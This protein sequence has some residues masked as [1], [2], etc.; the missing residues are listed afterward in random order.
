MKYKK[1]TIPVCILFFLYSPLSFAFQ[2]QFQQPTYLL[3]KE[4]IQDIYTCDES[5]EECKVNFSVIDDENMLITDSGYICSWNFWG[6]TSEESEKCNPN[7][8]VYPV[9]TWTTSVE[10]QEKWTGEILWNQSMT[11]QN[12]PQNTQD[13]PEEDTE[14]S[15]WSEEYFSQWVIP[16]KDSHDASQE[17]ADNEDDV[18]TEGKQSD[19]FDVF[20]VFQSPTYLTNPYSVVQN[21][22]S[23]DSSKTECKVNL[24]LTQSADNTLL[25]GEY[26]CEWDFGFE[27]DIASDTCNPT[28]IVYPVWTFSIHV[29]VWKKSDPTFLVE[30]SLQITNTGYMPQKSWWWSSKNS[31]LSSATKT[32][33]SLPLPQIIIQ[34]GVDDNWN[35]TKKDCKTNFTSSPWDN[36]VR[37]EWKFPGGSFTKGTDQKC[38]P[39]MVTYGEWVF[40]VTLTYYQKDLP[41][42][43]IS[44][45]VKLTNTGNI[46]TPIVKNTSATKKPTSQP[47]TESSSAFLKDSISSPFQ[48]TTLGNIPL[49]TPDIWEVRIS[50]VLPY[51][52]SDEESFLE[53]TNTT[54]NVFSLAWCTLESLQSGKYDIMP[55]WMESI[56]SKE[57]RKISGKYLPTLSHTGKESVSL[58]CSS[59]TIDS[60]LRN[61]FIPK[62]FL[63]EPKY[64]VQ[65]IQYIEKIPDIPRY[66]IT[67]TNNTTLDTIVNHPLRDI[68]HIALLPISARE[69]E[70]HIL[71]ILQESFVYDIETREEKIHIT[72][73]TL[74]SMKVKITLEWENEKH[75]HQEFST[76]SDGYGNFSLSL[77]Q[78]YIPSPQHI[79]MTPSLEWKKWEY[80]QIADTTTIYVSPKTPKET[81][82]ITTNAPTE[83]EA[84][85]FSSTTQNIPS[86]PPKV[87]SH[88]EAK[89]KAPPSVVQPHLQAFI[90]VQGK[91]GKNKELSDNT[92][93][94]KN[95]ET[96]SVNF[97]GR[98]SQGENV[99]YF[100]DFGDFQYEWDNPPALTFEKWEHE[101]SLTITNADNMSDTAYFFLHV[102]GKTEKLA[103]KTNTV[104]TSIPKTISAPSDRK[105]NILSLQRFEKDFLGESVWELSQPPLIA[106]TA[107]INTSESVFQVYTPPSSQRWYHIWAS[108]VII[109]MFCGGSF[110]ILKRRGIL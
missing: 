40:D 16:P 60:L 7:T 15:E 81:L 8:V 58:V 100:W 43:R 106:G 48:N 63:I 19:T 35:C 96:C 103:K 32:R 49:P 34:S 110:W 80:Y 10:I 68:G 67:Y 4:N 105:D 38:N 88:Q 56:G 2:I 73:N 107:D 30:Q 90:S 86:V 45:T 28:T 5:K 27:T 74:P 11:I 101:I 92:L 36:A 108:L 72:G 71:H 9:W 31:P 79:F 18:H 37:C 98:N 22:Y 59:Q 61:I 97:D 104:T 62:G 33:L 109:L 94:C 12:I 64:H 17:S 25:S 69:K 85:I 55:F 42:N 41:E 70:E 66:I 29:S 76:V 84:Q 77:H 82:G 51:P 26:L 78:A 75:T 91:I 23:C 24:A 93:L 65:H 1:Y 50:A 6:I 52:L 39:G 14:K 47:W 46:V 3:E 44:T 89:H 57:V 13:H 102:E 20:F 99:E 53:L 54:Q 83:K 95:V 21:K 87:V